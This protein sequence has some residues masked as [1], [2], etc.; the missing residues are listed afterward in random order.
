MK[1]VLSNR[2]FPHSNNGSLFRSGGRVRIDNSSFRHRSKSPGLFVPLDP[3]LNKYG[4]GAGK[5]LIDIHKTADSEKVQKDL[6]GVN[7]PTAYF[8]RLSEKYR[9]H[10]LEL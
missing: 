1:S 9:E 10:F 5:P 3:V 7:G 2:S 6:M 4:M 8:K